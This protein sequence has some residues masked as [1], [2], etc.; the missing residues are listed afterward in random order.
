MPANN[1]LRV[2]GL[3]FDT[4]RGNLRDFIAAKPEFKDHDFNSSAIGSLLDLLAYNS[5]YN[6]FYVNMAVNEAFLDSA[7]LRENVV[8][9]A[10]SLG[11]TPRSAY[12]ATATI[13]IKF[14][15]ANSTTRGVITIPKGTTFNS[16]ANN[17]VLYFSTTD[18][19]SITPNT[20]NG[21]SAN[22]AIVEGL[23]LT[24]Q[25]TKTA[26]NNSF[27]IPNANVDSRYIDVTVRTSG[28]NATYTKAS[29]LYEV[30]G[31]SQIY[32]LEEYA[33]NRPIITFG[34]NVL[35]KRPDVGSTIFVDY[36]VVNT[37]DGNGANNFTSSASIGGESNFTITTVSRAAGGSVAE[38]I[39]DIRFN[40]S[41][42]FETQERAVTT[43][44][45]KRI[46]NAQYGDLVRSIQVF[47]GELAD[48]PVYGKVYVAIRP[49]VGTVLSNSQKSQIT[50]TLDSYVPQSI[51]P[52]IIDPTYLYI[53][54]TVKTRVDFTLTNRSA[55]QIATLLSNAMISYESNSLGS[56]SQKFFPSRLLDQMDNVDD[57]ILGSELSV[58][59]QKR[60]RPDLSRVASYT[61]R[62]ENGIENQGVNAHPGYLTSTTFV[63]NNVT[64]YFDD[65][66]FG[67]LR[68]R[69]YAPPNAIIVAK[70]G[71]VDYQNGIVIISDFQPSSYTGDEIA[72][73]VETSVSIIAGGKN[74]IL[75]IREAL[76]QVFNDKT[77]NIDATIRNPATDG[78]TFTIQETSLTSEIT[79]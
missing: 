27:V 78:Q 42:N 54:P 55:A 53:I 9:R 7:Q 10:K 49:S 45:Y 2:T 29:T 11:Y 3:D 24:H 59:I 26:S 63:Y 73:S 60:F 22:I 33:N 64:C 6:A 14:P 12:G 71:T 30:N 46:V 36:R 62:F 47:G 31:N 74:T 76:I 28:T 32:Y 75:L 66:G 67:N 69:Q 51:D 39:D 15:D 13:N 41:K 56:F 38:E 70:A 61:L 40:A 52:V 57:G 18:A 44:D 21:F 58:E 72:M 17:L 5:Y 37:T 8:S 34:N 20:T 4:I 68:I 43:E 77:G 48:P 1:T 19:V 65:D 23:Q 16:S 79:Y 35:G 25:F 50:T